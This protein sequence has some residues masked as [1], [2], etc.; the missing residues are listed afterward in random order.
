METP[1]GKTRVCFLY[2]N[3]GRGHPFYL[4]GI[5]EALIRKGRIGLVRSEQNVFEITRG[6]GRLS[7][8]TARWLYRAGSSGGAAGRIYA[9][10]RRSGDYNRSSA[11]LRLLGKQIRTHYDEQQPIIVAHPSLVGILRNRPNLF[12]QHGE[13]VVPSEARVGGADTVFVPTRDAAA[14]FVEAGYHEDQVFVSGLCVEPALVRQAADVYARRLARLADHESL[15]GAF[16]SSGAEPK[17]HVAR[18]IEASVST[19][20]EGHRVIVFARQGG[21]LESQLIQAFR[22]HAIAFERLDVSQMVQDSSPRALLVVY[23]T[24]REENSLTAKFFPRFDFLI[25]PPHERVNWAVG[26]GLPMFAVGPAIG[27]FAPLNAELLEQSGAGQVL[28][29][30]AS[31]HN[32]ARTI[33]QF[34]H[35]GRMTE[36]ARAG[37]GHSSIDGFARIADFLNARFSSGE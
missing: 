20:H 14:A 33:R 1:A 34:R 26:L 13:L 12:Y 24:R 11:M 6:L 4:D 16:F 9:R 36:M 30:I 10:L 21:R 37:W 8:S 18:L 27:P 23:R 22:R 29:T 5:I 31:A 17:P 35:K 19:I 2:T 15:T 28:S 32:L 25:A 3:I 7:W